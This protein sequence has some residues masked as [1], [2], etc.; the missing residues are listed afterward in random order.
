MVMISGN[1]LDNFGAYPMKK[2][3]LMAVAALIS[4]QA[5]ANDGD[6]QYAFAQH[7]YEEG[8]E[9]F[10]LLEFKRFRFHNPQHAKAPDAMYTM[11]QI[12]LSYVQDTALAKQTLRDIGKQYP[13]SPV[14]AKAKQFADFIE[15]NSD[16]GGKPL[17]AYLA[18]RSQ[19]RSGDH[20]GAA[21]K[22]KMITDQYPKSNLADD[23]MY[24][25]GVLLLSNLKK[26]DLAAETFSKLMR[27]YPRT[28]LRA[29]AHLKFAEAVEADSGPK[30]ALPEYRDVARKYAKTAEGNAAL[31][32]IK[33]IEQKQ[34][35]VKRKYA[36][37]SAVS[38]KVVREEKLRG[39]YVISIELPTA[40]SDRNVQAT[41]NEALIKENSKR[42][43]PT[44][45]VQ[46]KAYFSYPVTAAGEVKWT[47]GKDPMYAVAERKGE[48]VLK[49]VFIDLLR[50]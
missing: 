17:L 3:F 10:A 14:A 27:S 1:D 18:A 42:T 47:P 43:N 38:Y 15:V 35:V 25:Y 49:D 7:L 37:E 23:A 46:I 5:A 26:P 2:T 50:K 32:R 4:L 16:H 29:K 31:A 41:L 44:D 13:R 40:S 33:A 21:Q 6:K 22:F 45:K 20:I 39:N 12:Y 30:V 48:D 28:S 24:E 36:K 19:A 11:A 8:S 9:A 34:F